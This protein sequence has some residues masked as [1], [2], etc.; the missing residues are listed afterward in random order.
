MWDRE[1]SL[2]D[3]ILVLLEHLCAN[4]V[5][6]YRLFENDGGR[7]AELSGLDALSLQM[8]YEVTDF[9]DKMPGGF[10]IYRANEDEEILYANQGLLQI[11]QCDNMTEFRELTHNSFRGLVCEED[12]DVVETSIQ[13]QIDSSQYDL[14]YVEYRIF[15]KDGSMRWIE[16]Y[17]HFVHSK[18]LG[19][20]F[21]VFLVDAT[22]KAER[23]RIKEALLRQEK[24][25]SEQRWRSRMEEYD[26]ERALIN[27]EYLRRMEVIEGLS[28]NYDSIFYADLEED[29]I[30][31][32]RLG[33]RMESIFGGTYH[34]M[35]YAGC[36]QRY[37][38]D[39]VHPEDRARVTRETA[40]KCVRQQLEQNDVYYLNYRVLFEGE[41]QYLQVRFV[42]VGQQV[43][44]IVLGCR[45]VDDEL[46][47]ELEQK[48]ILEQALRDAHLSI[49]AKNTFLSNMSHDMRTPLN[50]IFG[51]TALA[52][53][54]LNDQE[55]VTGYLDRIDASSHQLLNL[56]DEVL[57]LSWL[58]SNEVRAEEKPCQLGEILEEVHSFLL[59]QALEKDIDFTLDCSGVRHDAIYGDPEKLNQLV[60]YLANN[61]VTYTP[62]G[63]KA[64]IIAREDEELSNSYSVYRV[65][66]Q[67]N[68]IGISE[69]FIQQI[70]E[71][72]TRERNTTLSGIHGVGLG[73]TIAR[74]LA[75]LLGGAIEVSSVVDKGSTFTV[76]LRL[77]TQPEAVPETE[78][79]ARRRILLVEDN[80][81]NTEIAS[82]ILRTLGFDVDTAVNGAIGVDKVRSSRPGDYDLIL[83]DIQ[84]PVMDGWEATRA[85]RAL[86]DKALAGIPIVA[87]SANVFDSDIQQSLDSGMNAHLAKPID[88]PLLQRTIEGFIEKHEK[89]ARP[90]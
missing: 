60:M 37:I 24:E 32:Y 48:Q 11:F 59:P 53:N 52:R 15:R 64:S 58:D 78:S 8:A 35:D 3:H 75:D 55:A 62:V 90:A 9:M 47:R 89:Q 44:Q 88:V 80:E 86:P 19:D 81:I 26:K 10:L 71:P 16:D 12:L 50:A 83:M 25:K 7:A 28:V 67:D 18:T 70:F 77:R 5:E 41:I 31:P 40:A 17:G 63:G 6:F 2:I 66:V 33:S 21:Y 85:I 82:E 46:R 36:I 45:R 34:T 42:N 54:H 20:I 30:L 74:N 65:I 27:Q 23:H 43:G 39:W 68:G 38:L 87:L 22:E 14:D 79:P 84:M 49:K 51:F 73:L 61:A 69:D 29:K 4:G 13:Q 72:F 1:R 76:T 57:K 56:I